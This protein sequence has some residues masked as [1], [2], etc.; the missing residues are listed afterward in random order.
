MAKRKTGAGMHLD[1]VLERA[2]QPKAE[3]S[4]PEVEETDPTPY[5][6]S[7]LD[8]HVPDHRVVRSGASSSAQV[9]PGDSDAA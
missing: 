9:D 3:P 8:R 1:G 2:P 7:I 4:A 5:I 6:V